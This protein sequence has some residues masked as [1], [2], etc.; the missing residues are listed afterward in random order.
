MAKE[1]LIAR[2]EASADAEIAQLLRTAEDE[3]DAIKQEA[4]RRSKA[5]AQQVQTELDRRVD[6]AQRQVRADVARELRAAQVQQRRAVLQEV[7]ERVLAAFM[8][9]EGA[10]RVAL[11]SKLVRS[12]DVEKGT[13][14]PAPGCSADIKKAMKEAGVS[15]EVKDEDSSISSGFRFE[16]GALSVDASFERLVDAALLNHESDIA[17]ILF[18]EEE[19]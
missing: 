5:H 13:V 18:R 10:Q 1:T 3:I 8:A 7:R 17:N 2:L 16:S 9:L 4:D 15:W 19:K 12:V 14:Y 11:F 6:V